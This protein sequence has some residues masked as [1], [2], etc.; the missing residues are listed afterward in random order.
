MS[1]HRSAGAAGSPPLLQLQG[2]EKIFP[3]EPQPVRA[4]DGIDLCVRAGEIHAVLG[5]NGAGKSTL[6]KIIFGLLRPD[7]GSMRWQGQPVQ[8]ASPQAARALG[9]GMVFQHFSLFDSLSVLENIALGLPAG[10]SPGQSLTPLRQRF[11]AITASY[12]LPLDADRP[13]QSLSVGER[14]RVELTRALL[15]SPRLLIL[16]EPTSVLT[17]Q[18]VDSLFVTLRQLAAEGCAILYISHKLDEIRR[19]CSRCTVLRAGKV[20]GEVD[21]RQCSESQ[22][23]TLMI[24]AAPP[25]LHG[26][27]GNRGALRLSLHQLGLP[28]AQDFAVALHAISLELYAGEIL[29]IAGVSGN[30]QQAL[31]AALSGEDR[32]VAAGM[33]RIDG[34]ALGGAGP[35]VLRQRGL[36][37]VPEQRLGHAT[38]P[39]HSL[40]QNV[41][42][43]RAGPDTLRH[44]WLRPAGMAAMAAAVMQRFGVRAAGVQAQARSLSGGNLQKYIVGREVSAAPRILLLAQPT[45]GVDVGAAA[46]LRSELLA[47]RDAGVAILL[48]SEDLDELFALSDRL[49]VMAS[50]RLSPVVPTAQMTLERLGRWMSGLWEET[51]HAA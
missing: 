17:P 35:A 22:L 30:G 50:G 8:L 44:G 28:P 23:S 2:I 15:G 49:Q 18:A 37:Y 36:R 12:G 41:L 3:A 47:L 7:A 29:G 51:Q 38:V 32:R 25:A 48:L 26:R 43:T 13:V 34:E 11:E 20:V 4:N 40:S 31:M 16:D 42:L 10:W 45:W 46:Q 33:L 1:D 21:P 9:I 14:Q 5:E 27:T 24:G 19:L 6:M 39:E